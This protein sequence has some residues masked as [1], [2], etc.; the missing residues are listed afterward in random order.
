MP[1]VLYYYVDTL[2][3]ASN[4][5]KNTVKRNLK[6]IFKKQHP[7]IKF[8]EEMCVKEGHSNITYTN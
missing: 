1:D 3:V 6:V 4:N 8:T 7:T 2:D 5:K